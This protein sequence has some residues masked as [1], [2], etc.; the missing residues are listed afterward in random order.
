MYHQLKLWIESPYILQFGVPWTSGHMNNSIWKLFLRK[1]CRYRE[2]SYST[3]YLSIMQIFHNRP[4]HPQK[5]HL[6]SFHG[7][8]NSFVELVVEEIFTLVAVG[9]GLSNSVRSPYI[10]HGWSVWPCFWISG[11]NGRMLFFELRSRIPFCN[12]LNN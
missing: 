2:I 10:V 6:G 8:E 12:S 4:S 1:Y 3:E 11:L 9:F 7:I 5:C